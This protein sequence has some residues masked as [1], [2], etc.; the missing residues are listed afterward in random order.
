M[1]DRGRRRPPASGRP[2]VRG[3]VPGD[4]VRRARPGARG[5]V[6]GRSRGNTAPLCG[7]RREA[8]RRLLPPPAVSF[9]ASPADSRI[10]II[11]PNVSSRAYSQVAA[12]RS[13]ANDETTPRQRKDRSLVAAFA[14]TPYPR[15]RGPPSR[16]RMGLSRGGVSRGGD[17]STPA[18]LLLPPPTL[19][20][21][22]FFP[23]S[24]AYKPRT[25]TE[26]SRRRG[27][28]LSRS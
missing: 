24:R 7:H 5:R 6:T 17:A 8:A 9:A 3:R 4:A 18:T 20:Q 26:K 19:T 11:S 28:T 2:R 23:V 12:L 27:L 16:G 25:R 10:V 14:S 15:P 13:F 1:E 21:R 22:R